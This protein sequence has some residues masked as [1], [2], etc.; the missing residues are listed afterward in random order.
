MGRS[1][2]GKTTCNMYGLVKTLQGEST[3][4]MLQLCWERETPMH[5]ELVHK[6]DLYN[7]FV[8]NY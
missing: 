7:G 1:Q 2:L 5:S 6:L 3:C 8:F 4:K